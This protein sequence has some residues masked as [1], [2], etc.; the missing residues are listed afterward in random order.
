MGP[1]LEAPADI[2]DFPVFPAGT[3]SILS[4]CLTREIWEKLRL[5]KVN[6]CSF[7][8]MIFSGCKLTESSVGVYA[9]SHES[10]KAFAP[11]FD[12]VIESYHGHDF[13]KLDCPDLAVDKEA[14]I[15]S[16]RVRIARNL[17]EYRLGTSISTEKRREVESKVVSVLEKLDGELA[18][19]YFSLEKMTDSE[20]KELIAD[21]FLFKG[22]DKFL[23]SSGLERDWP[24]ARGIFHN[25]D[26][27]FL[28]WLNK[29]DQLRIISMQK[30]FNLR[31]ILDRS[32]AEK[33]RLEIR[34]KNGEQSE[35]SD[36]FDIS[37]ARRLGRSE[38]QLVQDMYNG[39]RALITAEKS[40][41]AQKR[42]SRRRQQRQRFCL[43]KY[44]YF[45]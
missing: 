20:R 9:G 18:G 45:K 31:Q 44:I 17:A 24:Q 27:T 11:L 21:H 25:S 5:K 8:K 15:I 28:V 10:Y 6:G 23:A 30:G 16:T 12:K 22:G 1:H 33:Y 26:K 29:E 4:N 38:V 36:V 39:V 7:E 19:K 32:I 40:L 41:F 35:K 2:I 37:Y 43:W 14:M 3:K 13:S 34:G 42:R